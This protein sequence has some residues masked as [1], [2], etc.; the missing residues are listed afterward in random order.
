MTMEEFAFLDA[1]EDQLLDWMDAGKGPWVAY[2]ADRPDVPEVV[3]TELGRSA[4]N[5][6]LNVIASE[7]MVVIA[8]SETE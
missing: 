5:T 6:G 7:T 1:L 2:K 8:V 4:R 3:W